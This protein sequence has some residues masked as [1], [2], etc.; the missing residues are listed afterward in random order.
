M[1]LM[2]LALHIPILFNGLFPL[3]G[4]FQYSLNGIYFLDLS[5]VLLIGLTW[6]VFKLRYWAWWGATAYVCTMTASAVISLLSVDPH[7]IIARMKFTRLELKALQGVPVEGFHLALMVS[8]PAL[9]TLVLLL[10]SRRHF[11]QHEFPEM[12]RP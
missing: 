10:R 7:E 5:I 4:S 6:G 12:I 3:F 8:L 2:T 1:T 9:L 11:G